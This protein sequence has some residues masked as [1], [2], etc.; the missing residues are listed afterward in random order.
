MYQKEH[1]KPIYRGVAN[2]GGGIFNRHNLNYIFFAV[3]ALLVA[4]F[5]YSQFLYSLNAPFALDDARMYLMLFED[6]F[7]DSNSL[8]EKLGYFFSETN[9]PHAKLTGRFFPIYTISSRGRL[10]F[11]FW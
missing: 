3:F 9:Y 7:L 5:L 10:I 6:R 1:M 8:P 2:M 11:N 4:T